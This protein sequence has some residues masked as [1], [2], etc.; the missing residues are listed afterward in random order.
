[1]WFILIAVDLSRP[2]EVAVADVSACL[3]RHGSSTSER[4]VYRVDTG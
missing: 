4:K 1:M 2:I 3:T